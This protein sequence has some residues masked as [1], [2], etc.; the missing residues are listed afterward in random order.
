M[1]VLLCA[2]YYLSASGI[3]IEGALQRCVK[4]PVDNAGQ[5]FRFPASTQLETTGGALDRQHR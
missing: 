2:R 5:R 1:F 3:D 4:N